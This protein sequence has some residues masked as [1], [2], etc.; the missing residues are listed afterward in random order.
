MLATYLKLSPDEMQ[1]AS[2]R[3]THEI[4]ASRPVYLN[5]NSLNYHVTPVSFRV[6][7][8]LG[9]GVAVGDRWLRFS[10]GCGVAAMAERGFRMI[11]GCDRFA[12]AG[13][14]ACGP[15]C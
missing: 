14:P 13:G 7:Q 2:R 9:L 11:A 8:A 6:S 5:T 12:A 15:A 3:M 1:S 10:G 4:A